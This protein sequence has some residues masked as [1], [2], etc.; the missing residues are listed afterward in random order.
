MYPLR[1]T[2]S[3]IRPTPILSECS[4]AS[5]VR[6]LR[7]PAPPPLTRP[8][9]SEERLVSANEI[10]RVRET[11]PRHV[12]AGGRIRHEQESARLHRAIGPSVR[13]RVPRLLP[14]SR[15]STVMLALR[16]LGVIREYPSDS[17]SKRPGS[18]VLFGPPRTGPPSET[19][20]HSTDHSNLTGS[21]HIRR[22]RRDSHRSRSSHGANRSRQMR[23]HET[24]SITNRTTLPLRNG[25]GAGI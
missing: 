9:L 23:T 6:A 18:S 7:A 8:L 24:H 17:S 13:T 10:E 3:R 11:R 19:G 25:R 14:L 16:R 4:A 20:R 5:R 22:R 12:E 2:G 21:L 15:R 1:Q